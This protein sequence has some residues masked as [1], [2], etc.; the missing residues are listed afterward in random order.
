MQS[1]LIVAQSKNLAQKM[2]AKKM[3]MGKDAVILVHSSRLHPSQLIRTMWP[4][5]EKNH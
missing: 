5:P 3:T 1:S 4:N 2:S